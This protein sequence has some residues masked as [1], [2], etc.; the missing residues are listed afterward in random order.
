MKFNSIKVVMSDKK[1]SILW[2]NQDQFCNESAGLYFKQVFENQIEFVAVEGQDETEKA[3]KEK[4]FDIVVASAELM[5]NRGLNDPNQ[6]Y[7]SATE[8]AQAVG[9]VSSE[10]DKKWAATAAQER[11]TKFVLIT[12]CNWDI[13]K[14]FKTENIAIVELISSGWPEKIRDIIQAKLDEKAKGA[15]AAVA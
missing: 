5:A 10:G 13:P 7:K 14:A 1:V 8:I 11:G 3:L 6:W 15:E 4:S 9:A 2:A 12:G